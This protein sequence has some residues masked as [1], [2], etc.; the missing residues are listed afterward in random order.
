[1]TKK[2]VGEG[3]DIVVIIEGI[4]ILKMIFVQSLKR[5][6][7]VAVAFLPRLAANIKDTPMIAMS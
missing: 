7:R 5:S 2:I 1:M 3:K 6:Q 4:S